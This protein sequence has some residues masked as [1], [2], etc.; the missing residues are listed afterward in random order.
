MLKF[1]SKFLDVSDNSTFL[2][3]EKK[4]TNKNY[5]PNLEFIYTF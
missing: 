1:I 3:K 4:S 5:I 2:I